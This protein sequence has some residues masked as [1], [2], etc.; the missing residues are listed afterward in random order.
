MTDTATPPDSE[1]HDWLHPLAANGDAP[2][3]QDLTNQHTDTI[4]GQ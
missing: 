1:L 3:W 2:D 4:T